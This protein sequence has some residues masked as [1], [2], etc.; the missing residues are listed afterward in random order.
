M[1]RKRP[2]AEYT[3]ALAERIY[4][5]KD[6]TVDQPMARAVSKIPLLFEHHKLDLHDKNCWPLLAVCLALA[7]VP[8]L[9]FSMPRGGRKRTWKAGQGDELVRAVKDVQSRIGVGPQDALVKLREDKRWKNYTVQNL[10]TRHREAQ[11]FQEQPEAWTPS[12][13]AL[14]VRRLQELLRAVLEDRALEPPSR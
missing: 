2:A 13:K 1:A 7:H 4:L 10:A 5:D 3:G 11:R 14:A 8:G 9:Q 6:E 12:L